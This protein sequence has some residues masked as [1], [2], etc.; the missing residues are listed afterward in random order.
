MLWSRSFT[1]LLFFSFSFLSL[2]KESECMAGERLPA[3]LAC[4]RWRGLTGEGVAKSLGTAGGGTS[5]TTCT[6]RRGR[7]KEEGRGMLLEL[8]RGLSGMAPS[9]TGPGDDQKSLSGI[10]LRHRVLADCIFP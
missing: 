3:L 2:M 1:N 4:V 7:G 9:R 8:E 10:T 5:S 6:A